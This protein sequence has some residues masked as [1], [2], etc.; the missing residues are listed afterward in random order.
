MQVL[1]LNLLFLKNNSI[2]RTYL[3]N[4]KYV[5]IVVKIFLVN[6]I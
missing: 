5:I 2:Y 4:F 1:Q 6:H 3:S